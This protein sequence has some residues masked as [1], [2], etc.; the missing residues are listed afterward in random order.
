[1]VLKNSNE[2]TLIQLLILSLFSQTIVLRNETLLII[3]AR[4]KQ[5]E[6]DLETPVVEHT[7]SLQRILVHEYSNDIAFFPSVKYILVYLIDID[8]RTYSTS[9]LHGFALRNSDLTKAF[10][11]MLRRK[12]KERQK[13]DI[14]F[15]LTPEELFSRLDT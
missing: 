10:R 7:S 8:P 13:E 14:I 12:L 2:C 5:G 9:T 11:R 6:H 15:P 3:A 1:M 4:K